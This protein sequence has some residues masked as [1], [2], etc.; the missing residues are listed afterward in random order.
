M[1]KE[2]IM[3]ELKENK[4]REGRLLKRSKFLREWRERWVVLTFNYIITFENK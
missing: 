3:I 4:I 1:S 2:I